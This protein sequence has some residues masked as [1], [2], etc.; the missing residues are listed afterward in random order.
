VAPCPTCGRTYPHEHVRAVYGRESSE[1]GE[2]SDFG[3]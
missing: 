3:D 2:D 1:G